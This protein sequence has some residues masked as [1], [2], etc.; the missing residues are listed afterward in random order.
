MELA[1][2]LLGKSGMRVSNVCLGTMTFGTEWGYGA[3]HSE[4]RRLFE[5]FLKVGGNFFDTANRY[6]EGSSERI[7]GE[8]IREFAVR[9]QVVVATKFSLRTLDG[10]PNDGGNHR[11]N[12]VQSLDASLKRLGMD[13]VDLFYLHAW[14]FSVEP[15]ELMYNL[16]LLVQSGKVLHIALSDIPAWVFSACMSIA[17]ERHYAQPVALQGEYS[18]LT[19]DMERDMLPAAAH[20]GVPVLAWGTLAGGAFSG[21]YLKGEGGRVP[22]NSLRRSDRANL[23]TQTVVELAARLGVQPIS[24][25]LA[26]TLQAPGKLIPIVGARNAEQLEQSLQGMALKIPEDVL[27]ELDKASAISYGFPHDFL[28]G[29]LVRQLQ[30]GPQYNQYPI[31]PL[32]RQNP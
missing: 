11:K 9:E 25:A 1:S 30:F 2:I 23:L 31:P 3:D 17:R 13:Y 5:A 4:S 26:W 28:R 18:L 19:R 14:D 24:L 6:T 29:D 21:K 10:K 12:M 7:L 27:A 32:Y 15:E 22:E 8:L 20:Y 16:N